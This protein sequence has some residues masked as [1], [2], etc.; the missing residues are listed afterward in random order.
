M[1]IYPTQDLED[2]YVTARPWYFFGMVLGV[3]AFTAIIIYLYDSR[4]ERNYQD[5][6]KKAKQA[7]AIVSSIFPEAVRRRLYQDDNSNSNN[8]VKGQGAFK[9]EVPVAVDA[10]K[11]K[12]KGFLKEGTDGLNNDKESS[13]K[14]EKAI[15]DLFPNTTILFADIVGFTAWSSQRYVILFRG[16][17]RLFLPP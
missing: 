5:T 8:P 7:G 2:E 3:F 17:H 12:L 11:A 14:P 16:F 6:Y 10:Q 1:S 15:A 9:Q 13:M 4:V